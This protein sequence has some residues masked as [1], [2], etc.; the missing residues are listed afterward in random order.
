MPSREQPPYPICPMHHTPTYVCGAECAQ[1][2]L[3]RAD[4]ERLLS[5]VPNAVGHRDLP[6]WERLRSALEATGQS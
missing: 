6:L 4:V 3:G 2:T 1:V 5:I